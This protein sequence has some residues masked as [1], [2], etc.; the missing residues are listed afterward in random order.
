MLEK[1]K[2]SWGDWV[3]AVVVF[4]A[5]PVVAWYLNVWWFKFMLDYLKVPHA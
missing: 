1:S 2:F 3:L 5:L 4:S